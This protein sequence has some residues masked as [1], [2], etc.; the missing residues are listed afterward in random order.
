MP[1]IADDCRG[2][3]S[4]AS[5]ASREWL[6][7]PLRTPLRNSLRTPLRTLSMPRTSDCGLARVPRQSGGRAGTSAVHR[8]GT[9]VRVCARSCA[10]CVKLC[11]RGSVTLRWRVDCCCRGRAAPTPPAVALVAWP[12]HDGVHWKCSCVFPCFP[13]CLF[14][15]SVHCGYTFLFCVPHPRTTHAYV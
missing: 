10:R 13:L 7:T 4:H 11:M 8:A 2:D 6:R 3:T 1:T 14:I 12:V 5:H 15:F 9:Y